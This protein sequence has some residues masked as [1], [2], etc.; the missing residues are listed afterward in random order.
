MRAAVAVGA[1]PTSCRRGVGSGA[2]WRASSPTRC[3]PTPDTCDGSS[4]SGIV[5]SVRCVAAIPMPS[6]AGG[7]TMPARSVDL[8]SA[9]AMLPDQ[10]AI[11]STA[12]GSFESPAFRTTKLST[13]SAIVFSRNTSCL[14]TGLRGDRRDG[15]QIT[16]C[17][18]SRE[19]E[20]V[21][22]KTTGR[23]ATPA[24]RS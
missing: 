18:S 23:F 14:R 20:S 12:D 11:G 19:A 15:M 6:I 3:S 24:T 13:S 21:I 17:P 22:W 5:A 2:R 1:G 16:S 9:S 7:K 8:R 10:I 4:T